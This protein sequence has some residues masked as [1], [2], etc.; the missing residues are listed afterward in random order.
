MFWLGVNKKGRDGDF[1]VVRNYEF[2]KGGECFVSFFCVVS[3]V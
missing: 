1:E 2:Y 3:E